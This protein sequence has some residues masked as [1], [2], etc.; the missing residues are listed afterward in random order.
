MASLT[1][2]ELKMTLVNHGVDLPSAAKKDD[3]I[4]LYEE[5][6][7]IGEKGKTDFSSD[8]EGELAIT[9]DGIK[10]SKKKNSTAKRVSR[11]SNVS[12]GIINGSVNADEDNKLTEENSLLVGAVDVSELTDEQLTEQLKAFGVD[13][14]PIV[15]STRA[16]YRKKLAISMREN[17]AIDEVQKSNGFHENAGAADSGLQN[18]GAADYSADEEALGVPEDSQESEDEQPSLEVRQSVTPTPEKR[19]SKKASTR[20][21]SRLSGSNF[22][23]PINDIRQRITGSTKE[24]SVSNDRYTPTPRRSIHSYKVTETSKETVTKTKDGSISRNFDYKK[25]TSTSDD[26]LDGTRNKIIR[27]LPRFFL[28]LILLAVGYYVYTN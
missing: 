18:G 8:E 16:I 14:G 24:S 3:L 27:L 28:L 25:E 1:K 2:E 10:V 6:P 11:K 9:D 23:S 4:A 13:V 26:E 12:A 15:D 5:L 21:S 7:G 19:V 20:S 17:S 22:M